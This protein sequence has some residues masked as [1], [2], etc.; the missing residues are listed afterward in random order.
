MKETETPCA[1]IPVGRAKR[2][3]NGMADTAGRAEP[4]TR[5]RW[6]RTLALLDAALK[7]WEANQP[8]RASVWRNQSRDQQDAVSRQDERVTANPR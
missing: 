5:A 8:R 1:G 6:T 4:P 7:V 2:R 3:L